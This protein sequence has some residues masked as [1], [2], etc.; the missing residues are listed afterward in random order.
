M[1]AQYAHDAFRLSLSLPLSLYLY[2]VGSSCRG[3]LVPPAGRLSPLPGLS[4][5]TIDHHH[6]NAEAAT[7][8]AAIRTRRQILVTATHKTAAA[9]HKI[10]AATAT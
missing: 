2:Q 10:A 8:A 9:A 1:P 5:S 7:A 4:A 3:R 6:L